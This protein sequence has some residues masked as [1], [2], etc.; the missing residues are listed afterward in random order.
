MKYNDNKKDNIEMDDM[1]IKSHLDTSLDLSGVIVSEDLINRTLEAIKKQ[2]TGQT[3]LE[4][5]KEASTTGTKKVIAW[6]RYVRSLAGVAAAVIIVAAGY[7]FLSGNYIGEKSSKDS[8]TPQ[9]SENMTTSTTDSTQQNDKIYNAGIES[10]TG[11]T[12]ANLFDAH[13]DSGTAVA[14]S[15]QPIASEPNDM[16]TATAET[17]PQFTIVAGTSAKDAT[18]SPDND[19]SLRKTDSDTLTSTDMAA[20]EVEASD[21]TNSLAKDADAGVSGTTTATTIQATMANVSG[22]GLTGV[23]AA[24][25]QS[26]PANKTVEGVILTF[27]EIFLLEP[28]NAAYI[29]IT[30]QVNGTVITLTDQAAIQDFYTVMDKHQFKYSAEASTE[31]NYTVEL[32]NPQQD[33]TFF[34]TVGEHI[35]VN[36]SDKDTTSQSI[37]D[38]VD[39]AL[40]TQDLMSIIVKYNK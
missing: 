22:D 13:D 1:N 7:S 19:T 23:P 17:T 11:D 3:N 4:E 2:S 6:N 28:E 15:T 20:K 39:G 9:M 12:S 34:M 30:D 18:E 21:A 27:R 16:T 32:S 29:T 25:N 38:A 33:T 8:A 35:T 36:F 31:Q 14:D 40:F 26:S 5:S 24:D 37:Y 10:Q